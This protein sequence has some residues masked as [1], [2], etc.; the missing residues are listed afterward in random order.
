MRLL[1]LLARQADDSGDLPRSVWLT[2]EHRDD[3]R[4]GPDSRASPYAA[5][6][7]VHFAEL[8]CPLV[9]NDDLSG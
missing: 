7:L 5:Q 8:N 1:R 9:M 3:P 4:M 6:H 2:R